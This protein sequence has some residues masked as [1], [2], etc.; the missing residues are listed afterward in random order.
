MKH[1]IS[2][3]LYILKHEY[4]GWLEKQALPGIEEINVTLNNL[5]LKKSYVIFILTCREYQKG[6]LI[7]SYN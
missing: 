7:Y 4:L 5:G 2:T 6:V 1:I 3:M